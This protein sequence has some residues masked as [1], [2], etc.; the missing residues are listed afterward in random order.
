MDRDSLHW[1]LVVKTGNYSQWAEDM[2]AWLISKG[3]WRLMRGDEVEPSVDEEELA[4]WCW[5]EGLIGCSGLLVNFTW[6]SQTIVKH[7][8]MVLRMTLSRFKRSSPLL[9]SKKSLEQV[10]T[11]RSYF[12]YPY[13]FWG[14]WPDNQNWHRHAQDQKSSPR[15][16]WYCQT[17]QGTCLYDHDSSWNQSFALSLQL[18]DN[19]SKDSLQAV[20]INKQQLHSSAQAT[21][22][23]PSHI[24]TQASFLFCLSC[25]QQGHGLD[26]YF[27]AKAL[28]NRSWRSAERQRNIAERPRLCKKSRP[29]P[30]TLPLCP[31]VLLQLVFHP[32]PLLLCFLYHLNHSGPQT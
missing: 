30:L 15:L 3:L 9:T 17:G 31:N 6:L 10:S 28:L 26:S 14:V 4:Y 5:S 12:L 1:R 19:M 25:G 23:S 22:L 13:M 16:V 29:H 27:A 2:R 21:I 11:L 8:C 32:L 24:I 20:F 18:L 7:N